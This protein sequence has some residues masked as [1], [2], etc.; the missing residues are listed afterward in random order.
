MDPILSVLEMGFICSLIVMGHLSIG[1]IS[2]N[3]P[4]NSSKV[5]RARAIKISTDLRKK[6]FQRNE[7]Y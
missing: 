6:S 3:E 2:S 5:S 7:R 4:E 1:L